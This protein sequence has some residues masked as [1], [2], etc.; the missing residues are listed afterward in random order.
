MGIGCA[1]KL[2][3]LADTQQEHHPP[4]MRRVSPVFLPTLVLIV[5]ALLAPAKA[6]TAGAGKGPFEG[7][8]D[9]KFSMEAAGGDLHL[10][11][12]GDRARLDMS[13]LMNPI[14]QPIT[15]GVL[16]DAK[17]PKKATMINDAM[18]VYSVID[19][20]DAPA[21]PDTSG[22]YTIKEVGKEKLLGYAC[23]HVTLKRPHELIDA[24]VTQDL[25][26]VYRVLRK[27]QQANPQYGAADAFRALDAAGKAG[28][29]MRC[30]VVRDGQ[31][32]TTEVKKIE[33]RALPASV[34]AV[35]A[36]Y[37]RSDLAAGAQPSPEQ[38]EEMKKMIQGALQGQ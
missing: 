4:S 32:V 26:D 15:M 20:A 7:V 17:D 23:T 28:L 14:P 19:L 34:F 33:R 13:L 24:W 27:L 11:M 2:L 30:I 31:R 38:I 3:L 1:D 37:Q 18:R 9:L 25:P 29:P 10:S 21:A 6:A 36:D 35:P 8:I 22:K 12:A 5:S 16:L